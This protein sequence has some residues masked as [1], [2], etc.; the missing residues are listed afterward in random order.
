[1]KVLKLLIKILKKKYENSTEE[2]NGLN[3]HI[4]KIKIDCDDLRNKL[5]KKQKEYEMLLTICSTGLQCRNALKNN[6]QVRQEIEKWKQRYGLSLNIS[7]SKRESFTEII[8]EK[9]PNDKTA[10]P[11]PSYDGWEKWITWIKDF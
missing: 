6:D 7:S 11:S 3:R 1:M 8:K 9:I 4:N 2:I 10:S 5:D